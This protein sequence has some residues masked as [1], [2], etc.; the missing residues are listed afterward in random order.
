LGKNGNT[1]KKSDSFHAKFLPALAAK[2]Q[3]NYGEY[4]VPYLLVPA[5][6]IKQ[7]GSYEE[8]IRLRRP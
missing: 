6:L 3:I 1:Q 5:I 4:K 7:Q 8:L 2:E